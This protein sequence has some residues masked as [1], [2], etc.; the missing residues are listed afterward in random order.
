MLPS[1]GGLVPK[2]PA[3]GLRPGCLSDCASAAPVG[4]LVQL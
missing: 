1:G 4:W 2:Y 3:A